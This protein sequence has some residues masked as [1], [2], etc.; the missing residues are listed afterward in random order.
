M[1][2]INTE[3]QMDKEKE[4]A[5]RREINDDHVSK[6]DRTAIVE[7]FRRIHPDE[8]ISADMTEAFIT[9]IFD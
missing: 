2:T 7:A 9:I 5:E 1:R 3:E 4:R 8:K 6:E